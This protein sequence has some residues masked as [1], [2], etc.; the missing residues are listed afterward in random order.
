MKARAVSAAH[1]DWSL[2]RSF[3]AALEHGSLLAAARALQTS[4]PTVGRH[5]AALEE[6]LGVLLFERTGRGLRP[7][8][9]GRR[10][11]EGALAMQSGADAL[12][13]S[14]MGSR[15]EL[16]GTVRLSASVAVATFLMPTVLAQMRHRLPDIQIELVASDAVSNLLRR[17]ADIALRMMR[18]GQGTVIA[19][20]IAT[21]TFGAF[22]H[23]D[24]LRRRGMPRNVADLLQHD[25][26]GDDRNQDILQGFRA[27]GL[28]ATPEHF[29]L[30]SDDVGVCWQAV[31]AGLGIG[32]LAHHVARTD[33][34]VLRL[35][36][37]HGGMTAT[38][39]LPTPPA[40][41]ATRRPL[42]A[43][44]SLLPG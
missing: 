43:S 24:Y 7:T 15:H 23:D 1:F 16:A 39:R 3:L 40:P 4:Q 13:R 11:A 9:T 21:V 18:P 34:R 8:E 35:S 42:V 28:A 44:T 20:R 27:L 37:W 2:I 29:A 12:A 10:L 25:L 38:L 36:R 22:A 5:I 6:Q 33:V 30:R 19:R 31:R 17:E 32:F 14:L 26:V 41:S